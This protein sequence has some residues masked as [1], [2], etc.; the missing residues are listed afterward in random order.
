MKAC[1][2]S[3]SSVYATV[4]ACF[5][6]SGFAAL[7]YQM[8]WMRQLAT[9][10][11]TSEIAVA[12][13]LAAYM[14]G[15]AIG[16]AVAARVMGS[17][18]RPILV[19]GILEATIAI[20][21]MAVPFLLQL[22]GIVYAS[23]FGGLSQPPDASGIGQSMFYLSIT[24][25]VLLVPTACMGATLPM[26][27][28]YAVHKDEDVGPR[29]GLLYSINTGGAIA[30]TLLAA[31]L[32]LPA[33]GL[34]GTILVG[35][36]VNL[37]VFGVAALLAKSSGVENSASNESKPTESRSIF[38]WCSESWILPIMLFSGVATFSY[39]VLWTRL[40]A[41]ILGGSVVAFATMLASFL[42]GIAI[43]SAIASR[44]AKT[45]AI[46]Q[47]GF[48]IAQ[49]GTA[50]TCIAIYLALDRYIPQTAGLLGNVSVAIALLL[51]ATLFIG[52]SFPFAVRILSRDESEAS[53]ASA[54]VYSWNTVGAI[55][56]AVVAGFVLIPMLKYEGAIKFTVAI[57][58]SLA[59]VAAIV[60]PPRRVPYAIG[61]AALLLMLLFGFS[62]GSPEAL[63]RVS[64][65]NDF[66]TG[67]IRYYGVG[68]SATVLMLERDGYLYLRTNGLPEAA[69][70]LKGA[71]PSKQTQRLLATLPVLARPNAE[72]MLIVGFGG[73]V[74]A[75][76]IP[77]SIT[78][79]DIVE[80]EPK[81]LEA[82]RFISAERNIDPLLDPRID[83]IINDARNALRL[84]EK[85]YD[86]IVSQPSHP[87]TAGASHLY[88]REF[89]S[90]VRSR[91]T[92]N[93]IFL[94]WMNT[95]FVSEPLLKSLVATLLDVFPHVRAYQFDE[96]VLFFLA[97]ESEIEPEAHILATGEPL[98]S[99]AKEFKRRGIGSVNDLVAAL[100]W[101]MHDLG[102]L[103]ADAPL[104]TDNDNRMAMRSVVALEN[105]ALPYSRLQELIQQYG[106]L[107]DPHSV[108]HQRMASA[109]D[110]V[111][112]LDRLELIN[113]K[114]LSSSLVETLAASGNPGSLLLEAKTLQMQHRGPDADQ[115]LL[116]A[117]ESDPNN[118]VAAY[119]L[120]KN[121][122]DAVVGRSLPARIQPYVGN[123]T[124]V[125]SAVITS[126]ESAQRR[127]LSHARKN[128]DLL[129]QAQPWEQW[130]LNAAKLRADW[131]ITATSIGESSGFA[132]EALAI[133]D[134]VISLRQDL[135]FYGMRMAAAFLANDYDAV[136]ETARRMTM[137]MREEFRFRTTAS[138]RGLSESELAKISLRLESM[139][140]GL[141][142]VRE[143]GRVAD[144]KF[145]SLDEGIS[146]LLQKTASHKE[147]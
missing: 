43:G 44:I 125:A 15:L 12:T 95:Q 138:D 52:A 90:L 112:V 56:G 66:R 9:V 76:D 19:Y 13:V 2:R 131:R 6:L 142:I 146:E 91:L 74:V 4:S 89:M 132:V 105:S 86:A 119:M 58:V 115:K 63:L 33:F 117:L 94:Q 68:R 78:D 30:G 93:G 11:G 22:A 25:V 97:A 126:M 47:A 143:S 104:I 106:S 62:P 37:G 64:P 134:E 1:I 110:F 17:I 49:L 38:G 67:E 24:F 42:A 65:L 99:R 140:T 3:P 120:L 70:D 54:R 133:I 69:T 5:F 10:F 85:R 101:D 71:P 130:Y 7:L 137:M 53:I 124:D 80:L 39:E 102:E 23:M 107:F 83:L 29:V 35:V 127:D 46:A 87:W 109:I 135:D 113:A 79:I 14:A 28:R 59:L 20:S 26:V 84:T 103:A 82:N 118:P 96:N 122:G 51:P 100:A 41:H 40:L 18:Q 72:S 144:Y 21:A 50:L 116:T 61:S 8:A 98:K 123:L 92:S 141:T 36:A 57:N 32:L 77:T 88:T 55:V 114:V 60:V 31:F 27:T 147:Q 139:Q 75:E 128:D 145:A 136:V 73:G 81:V 108:L 111:Y 121:R 48:I 34:W 45:R 16:A 129:A